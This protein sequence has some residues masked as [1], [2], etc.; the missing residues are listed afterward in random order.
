[1]MVHVNRFCNGLITSL[2]KWLILWP[3]SQVVQNIP[4]QTGNTETTNSYLAT[5]RTYPNSNGHRSLKT[6]GGCMYILLHRK[7][8]LMFLSVSIHL[9]CVHLQQ[10]DDVQFFSVYILFI[11]IIRMLSANYRSTSAPKTC[12]SL[13]CK[14]CVFV[15]NFLMWRATGIPRKNLVRKSMKIPY[16]PSKLYFTK[17]FLLSGL[18]SMITGDFDPGLSV[19]RSKTAAAQRFGSPVGPTGRSSGGVLFPSQDSI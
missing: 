8:Y 6:K 9:H 12:R 2:L 1:M 4:Q 11:I 18:A 3:L 14:L 16:P 13:V 5:S 19:P 15:K 7:V 17:C 10:Q